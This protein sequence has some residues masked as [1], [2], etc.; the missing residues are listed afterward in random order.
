MNKLGIW[1]IAIAAVLIIGSTT[2]AFADED[3]N[4]FKKIANQ[5]KKIAEAIEGLDPTVTVNVEPTPVDVNIN[6]E[7]T[8]NVLRTTSTINPSINCPDGSSISGV[9]ALSFTVDDFADYPISK[10]IGGGG[11]TLLSLFL[12]NVDIGENDFEITGTGE[13]AGNPSVCGFSG[14][15]FTFSVTGQCSVNTPLEMTTSLGMSISST[16]SAACLVVS[17]PGVGIIAPG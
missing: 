12:Y 13:V 8:K 3:K 5:L 9:S 17:D 1:G 4:F 10:V 2:L 15:P 6:S 16:G 7:A 11:S 14:T